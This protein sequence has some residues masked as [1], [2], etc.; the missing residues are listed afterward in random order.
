MKHL[1]INDIRIKVNYYDDEP[2]M[3]ASIEFINT[4]SDNV[5]YYWNNTTDEEGFVLEFDVDELFG[6]GY[7]DNLISGDDY[8]Y[9]HDFINLKDTDDLNSCLHSC[10]LSLGEPL[11]ADNTVYAVQAY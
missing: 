8:D 10:G 7:F 1:N 2:T 6:S 4:D 11:N 3:I 9:I 5:G